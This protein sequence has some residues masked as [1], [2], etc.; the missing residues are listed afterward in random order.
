MNP[1]KPKIA[2]VY[3]MFPHYRSAI[4][5]AMDRSEHFEFTFVGDTKPFQG[6]EAVD[7]RDVSNFRHTRFRT[8]G[9]FF[10]QEGICALAANTD[11]NAIIFLGNPNFLSTWIAAAIARLTRKKV[12]FWTHGWLR[13]EPWT[14]ARFRNLFY[15]LANRILVYGSRAKQL[16]ASSGYPEDRIDVIFNSLD[17]ERSQKV[18]RSIKVGELPVKVDPRSSFRADRP[19]VVCTARL[20]PA[21]RF[22]LLFEAAGK[23]KSENLPINIILV[24]DGPER[25]ALE[26]LANRLKIDVHFWGAC[27]DEAIL[28]QI[29]FE[30]D[31][32]CSPG[33]IGLTVIHSPHLWHSRNHAFRHE[34]SNA[35]S[36]GDRPRQN[37]TIFSL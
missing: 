9:P 6:I 35:G 24:G 2:V 36:R 34:Q 11:F 4:M 25:Q 19:L 3:H 17:F 1:S 16:G 26:L 33:K 12:L 10:W 27:Y 13:P 18:L 14:K 30:A 29:I 5:R 20:T 8:L 22:D 7:S 23:L 15:R 21:C 37:W 31:L 28:G 32:S